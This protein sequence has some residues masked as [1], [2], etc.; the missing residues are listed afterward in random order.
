MTP[1]ALLGPHIILSPSPPPT[2]LGQDS[3]TFGIGSSPEEK[4]PAEATK[5][6]GM[7]GRQGAQAE[8]GREQAE[9]TCPGADCSSAEG[10]RPA[11]LG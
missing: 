2:P 8:P 7:F 6:Q 4:G 10:A 9:A 5:P 11:A 1:A 3:P